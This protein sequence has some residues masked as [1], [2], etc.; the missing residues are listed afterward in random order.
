MKKICVIIF[1]AFSL[2]S[3]AQGYERINNSVFKNGEKLSFRVAYNSVL[4]GSLTAG[5]A[6][7]EVFPNET[8]INNQ[9]TVH[10]V[11]KAWTTGFIEVFYKLNNQL[12]SYINPTTYEPVRFVRSLR[13]NRYRKE[14][15]INFNHKELTA[16]HEKRKVKIIKNTQDVISIL[17]FAR[18]LS[19]EALKPGQYFQVPYFLDDSI[20][21]SRIIYE[22]KEKIKTRSGIY[23][24][25]KLKPLVLIGDVFNDTYPMTIWLTD[26]NYRL[27]VLIKSKLKIGEAR[28][29]L[30][31]NGNINT[32]GFKLPNKK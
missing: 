5:K 14:E 9:S 26:D 20:F 30:I 28:L 18:S 31:D 17:Y 15:T 27:P 11:A 29:E 25:I 7:L 12:E 2:T 8:V 10:A 1:T 3:I 23:N 21:H 4:T 13:E 22:G 32:S 24:C 6:T 19:V 16:V